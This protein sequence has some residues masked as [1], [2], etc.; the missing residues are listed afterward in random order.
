MFLRRYVYRHFGSQVRTLLMGWSRLDNSEWERSFH[1]KEYS[2]IANLY[3][4]YICL[5]N[6]LLYKEII[7]MEADAFY[8]LLWFY[9]CAE[10]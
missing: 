9:F 8:Y 10:T 1:G 7:P 4:T 2:L 6:M 5:S 3:Q